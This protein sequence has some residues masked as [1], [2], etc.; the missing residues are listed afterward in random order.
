[1]AQKK[2]YLDP[3][4]TPLKYFKF[5][6]VCLILGVLLRIAQVINLFADEF[7][8]YSTAFVVIGFILNLAAVVGM[9]GMQ[10]YGVL[11][12]HGVY[13]LSI[14]DGLV[15][16]VIA[17][18]YNLSSDFFGEVFGQIFGSAIVLA[19][20]WVY[21]SKRRLLFDPMPAADVAPAVAVTNENMAVSE[22]NVAP[23]PANQSFATTAPSVRFCRKCGAKLLEGSKF[24]SYCGVATVE[25][26]E[27][28]LP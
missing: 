6:K 22:R 28:V 15:A 2:L 19:I 1:M 11:S 17:S 18:V 24:C 20:N 13:I 3:A 10:W 16:L 9:N 14:V 25:D 23:Q 21:F 26:V 4:N 7:N 12:F 8:W 27:N 5:L